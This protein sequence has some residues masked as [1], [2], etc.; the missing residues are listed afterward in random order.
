M[1]YFI[2]IAYNGTQFHGWQRQPNAAS[3]QQ[4][5]ED[6]LA[7]LFGKTIAITGSGRTDTGVHARR[8]FAH[9]DIASIP[10]P[11]HRLATSLNNMCGRNIM[12]Q[13]IFPVSNDLHARF[14]AIRRT[15]RYFISYANLPFG[16]EY[17]WFSPTNLNVDAMNE[18]ADYLTTISDFT[19]FAKLHSD[20]KTNICMVDKAL[21]TPYSDF[22][23]GNGIMFEI[24]ADRF[25]RNMVRAIVGTL[26]DVGRNKISY[27]EFKKIIQLRNRCEAGTSMPPHALFLWDV[28]YNFNDSMHY[29]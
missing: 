16:K 4:T 25:L 18:C 28:E 23:G 5:I 22:C 12:I 2:E 24:S 21:W 9:F 6:N 10:F 29:E 3:I 8:T 13:R 11:L 19:S 27:P 7:I 17:A 15:Y 14:S 1:R 20:A 26:V